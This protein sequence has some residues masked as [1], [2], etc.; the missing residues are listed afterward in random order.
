MYQRAARIEYRAA[1]TTRWLWTR[2]LVLRWDLSQPLQTVL[3]RMR[4]KKGGEL[5][6]ARK[7]L[8]L[9]RKSNSTYGLAR[10]VY[11]WMS[12]ASHLCHQPEHDIGRKLTKLRKYFARWQ[13]RTSR[14]GLK[15]ELLADV[16]HTRLP[17]SNHDDRPREIKV[18]F[19]TR[20]RTPRMRKHLESVS[21]DARVGIQKSDTRASI[22]PGLW[23]SN[24]GYP[25]SSKGKDT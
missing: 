4:Y 20:R 13:K 21:G 16:R 11:G 6:T 12:K 3:F 8:G 7:G 23:G 5:Q 10:A 25:R 17:E 22:R 18:D 9:E 1:T 15:S 19:L 2:S 14:L 24:I